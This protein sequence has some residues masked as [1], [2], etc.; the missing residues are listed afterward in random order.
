[1][2]F[3]FNLNDVKLWRILII[4]KYV[5]VVKCRE[6]NFYLICIIWLILEFVNF[7]VKIMVILEKELYVSL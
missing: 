3:V 6:V 2:Y 5:I 4:I 7:V 1:M